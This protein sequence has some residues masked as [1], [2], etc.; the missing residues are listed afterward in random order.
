MFKV[1]V[2]VFFEYFRLCLATIF[3]FREIVDPGGSTVCVID[4]TVTVHVIKER[5]VS[6]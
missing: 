6:C 5:G 4:P 3:E 1:N 2:I